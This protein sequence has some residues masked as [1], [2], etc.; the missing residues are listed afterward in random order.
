M[1]NIN[2]RVCIEVVILGSACVYVYVYFSRYGRMIYALF[3]F[4]VFYLR[5]FFFFYYSNAITIYATKRITVKSRAIITYVHVQVCIQVRISM[6]IADDLCLHQVY[7]FT[8]KLYL[9]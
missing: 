8:L 2:I 5:R 1:A 4:V 9:V 6:H 7:I 3:T